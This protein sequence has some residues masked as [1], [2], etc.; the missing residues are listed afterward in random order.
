[1]L[2]VLTST[3][4]NDGRLCQ[5]YFVMSDNI[6]TR[7]QS[8]ESPQHDKIDPPT[9]SSARTRKTAFKIFALLL[10][11]AAL[12]YVLWKYLNQHEVDTDNAYVGAN[13]AAVTSMLNAQVVSVNVNDTQSVHRGDILVQLDDRDAKIAL[14]QAQA[15]LI[16]AQRQFKQSKATSGSLDSQVAAS[17]D[18]I[19]S[20]K[21]QLTKVQADYAKAMDALQRRQQL[22]AMGAVSK[23]ELTSAQ[24]NVN[25]ARAA[26]S[27]AQAA[28]AQAE[29]NRKALQSNL[30]ANNALLQ[31]SNEDDLP[32]VLV[33]RANVE[34]AQLDLERTTIRAPI[35]GIIAGRNVQV[36]QRIASGSVVLK[37]VPVQ[38]MYV[39][40]NFKESQLAHVR[41]GQAVTLTSD[42]Y[43]KEV[44][45]H[46]RVEGFSGGTGAAFALIPAQNATGNWIKVVQRLPVRISLDEKELQAH[47]LRVGLSMKATIDLGQS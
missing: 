42:Y 11:I 10:I 44:V 22:A 30:A 17:A 40:A 4:K 1:M 35:D 24:A 37:I 36:G 47:P 2:C 16:K 46:G 7:D 38:Q 6:S 34:K 14:A 13:V 43:G 3:L 20:A 15:Q 45:Y 5:D 28:I 23:E 19:N 33:A 32:D 18:A 9:P 27:I 39:D 41:T 21:A 12:G 25:T 31:G 26:V 29:S 8:N